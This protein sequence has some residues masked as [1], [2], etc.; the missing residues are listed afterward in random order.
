MFNLP[1]NYH[2]NAGVNQQLNTLLDNMHS[3]DC[4]Y[5]TELQ[6]KEHYP[7]AHQSMGDDVYMYYLSVSS[8][9]ESMNRANMSV[10]RAAAVDVLIASIQLSRLESK[11]YEQ[12]KK[13]AWK[14]TTPLTPFGMKLMQDAFKDVHVHEYACDV[15]ILDDHYDQETVSKLAANDHVYN[16]MIPKVSSGGSW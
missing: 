11:N 10:R 2:T 5:L 12:F 3:T 1:S 6:N 4:N 7:T 9:N 14:T 16:L 13:D 15:M 8:G